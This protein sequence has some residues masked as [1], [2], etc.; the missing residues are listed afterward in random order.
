MGRIAST[1][2]DHAYLTSDNPRTEE[3]KTIIDDTLK[4]V[5]DR[6]KCQVIEDRAMAIKTALSRISDGDI[7]VIAGKGH[8]DYQVIGAVKKY[9]S[10]IDVAKSEL[11]K[12]GYGNDSQ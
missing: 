2:A 10:D 12:S 3:P 11:R 5:V 8:E 9:F 4:G 7:L 6:K 1:L